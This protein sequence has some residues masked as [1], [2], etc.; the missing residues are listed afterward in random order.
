LNSYLNSAHYA[1]EVAQA[2][3]KTEYCDEQEDEPALLRVLVFAAQEFHDRK[4]EGEFDEEE[5]GGRG[6][7]YRA[8]HDVLLEVRLGGSPELYSYE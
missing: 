8:A 6:A 3:S 2:G 4:S 7:H 1:E 5:Q